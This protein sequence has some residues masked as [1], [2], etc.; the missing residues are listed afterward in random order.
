MSMDHIAGWLCAVVALAF[1]AMHVVTDPKKSQWVTLPFYVRFG[2]LLSGALFFARAM[3]FVDIR[4]DPSAQ[5]HINGEGFAA[6]VVLTYTIGSFAMFLV[7]KVL[8]GHGWE[9]LQHAERAE[10]DPNNVAVVMT[11]AEVLNQLDRDGV[12]I[13]NRDLTQR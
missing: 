13:I 5:G 11:K 3:N 2:F 6:L 7:T 8:E 4:D 12:H 10:H 9:R 1:F